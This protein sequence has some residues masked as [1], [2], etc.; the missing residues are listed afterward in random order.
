MPDD[1]AEAEDLL[2]DDPQPAPAREAAPEWLVNFRRSEFRRGF[3]VSG[4]GYGVVFS[5]RTSEVLVV[6]C[7]NLSSAREDTLDR[8]P[9]GYGFVAKNG[10]SQLGIM[11]FDAD[12][13]RNDG[14]LGYMQELAQSGFFR[15]FRK[16]VMTGTS[17][18]G[19]AACAF[20]SLAPGCTVIAFSP[21]STLKKDLVPW[22]SRF[23]SG[24]RADWSGA[25]ADGAAESVDAERVFLVYD[26]GFAPD[27]QHV[28]RFTAPNVVRL[29]ARYSGHKSALFLR[30]AG[31][32][33]SVVRST[34]EG[35]MSEA[36]FFRIYRGGRSL[37]WY[38]HAVQARLVEGKRHKLLPRFA[39]AVRKLGNEPIARS[40]EA[41]AV[42]AGVMAPRPR[43]A[44]PRPAVPRPS[45]PRPAA[46]RPT[47][48][49]PA[50][51]GPAGEKPAPQNAPLGPHQQRL[52][53]AQGRVPEQPAPEFR[54]APPP[55]E[56]PPEPEAWAD[57]YHTDPGL[58]PLQ[59]AGDLPWQLAQRARR[60]GSWG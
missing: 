25:F 38:L 15:R 13:F 54:P 22:E 9:W 50:P 53:A 8:L 12:W 55:P 42:E 37:P 28:E 46:P 17:M 49:G 44:A 40:A 36:E 27:L 2:A 20:A 48:A 4:E 26:P 47:A 56:P 33:S 14:L 21:Q 30:R 60:Q 39:A 29:P 57:L 11:T 24:R 6:S 5:D 59:P 18:G 7:D 19:Y 31:L 58:P 3:Y 23:P 45:A 32:L 43:P 34:V 52:L 35:H 41:K 1:D 16:V 51:Q 10:W